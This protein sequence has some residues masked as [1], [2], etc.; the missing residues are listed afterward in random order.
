MLVQEITEKQIAGGRE[1]CPAQF[2]VPAETQTIASKGLRSA[3]PSERRTSF[4]VH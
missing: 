3:S 1:G 4:K 2:H